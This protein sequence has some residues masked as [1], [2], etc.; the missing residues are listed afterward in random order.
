MKKA[1]KMEK[2][3]I[4]PVS[5]KADSGYTWKWRCLSGKAKSAS[6]F[7]FY[8]DCLENARQV[9]YEVELTHAYG[10]TAPGGAP[11]RLR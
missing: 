5:S 8:F 10:M 1:E 9:G 7:R 11:S 2:A 3:E 6:G 4:Y